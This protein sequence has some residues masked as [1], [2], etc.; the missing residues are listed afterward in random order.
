MKKC[1]MVLVALL[2][3]SLAA[4]NSSTTTP[5]DDEG[6]ATAAG[7]S[8]T[9][10]GTL[11]SGTITANIAKSTT[12]AEGYTIVAIDNTTNKAYPATTAADGTFSVDVPSGSSYVLSIVNDGS[13]VGPVV[14]GGSGTAVNTAI[15]PTAD[16]DIG[17]MTVDETSGYAAVETAPSFVDSDVEVVAEDGVP[18]GVGESGKNLYSGI[19]N[20]EDGDIDK[21]GIPNL[22]DADEDNDRVRNGIAAAAST[23]EVVSDYVSQVYMTSNIWADHNTTENAYDLIAMRLHVVPVEG[24]EDMIASVACTDIPAAIASTATVRYADSLLA[25]EAEDDENSVW[26]DVGYTFYELD[27]GDGWIVSIKPGAALTVGDT[28]TIRV[29]Y[30]D[31]TYEDFFVALPYF[32]TDWPRLLT[33]NDVDI[34][35]VTGVNAEFGTKGR[36]ITFSGE[37][38]TLTFS[39]VEDEDGN[40]LDGPSYKLGYAVTTLDSD[41]DSW[42]VPS[43]TE[44][45]A[46]TDNSDDTLTYIVPTTTVDTY[47]IVPVAET[48]DDQRNGEEVWF[49]RSVQAL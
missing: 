30:T 33:F 49:T 17:S 15:T 21:D 40:I 34:S 36:P 38:L 35:G 10:T 16:S 42:L 8:V 22:F 47:Y 6:G 48:A 45:F 5:S 7:E 23:K 14:F 19:T 27:A 43:S 4:C 28:F 12:A 11:G 46:A 2:V 31:A 9:L 32:L 25:A 3:L 24:Q 1:S 26:A 37:T 20:G 29:T 18:I 44:E 13:Y 39:K 41:T